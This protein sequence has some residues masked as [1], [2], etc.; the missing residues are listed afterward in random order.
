MF[1]SFFLIKK[2]IPN[3]FRS[4]LLPFLPCFSLVF[5]PPLHDDTRVA[6]N[7]GPQL[8]SFL[9]D[10]AGNGG[11][12]HL[13]LGV[14]NDAGVVLK[15]EEDTVE[16]LPGLGLANNDGG[17]DLLAQLGLTLLDG[18]DDHVTDTTSGQAVQ[19]G[20]GTL[21]GDHVQV[22]GTGVVGAV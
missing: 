19:T 2:S 10:G 16:A 11:A 18:G 5:P 9:T 15:V 14:D 21:D 17:V 6:G 12:L 22:A 7:T 4:L 1:F 3:N 20:T 13:T 8:G